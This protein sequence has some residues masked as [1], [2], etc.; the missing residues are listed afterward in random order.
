MTDDL[1]NVC[2]VLCT[3]AILWCAGVYVGAVVRAIV[4]S[5]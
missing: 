4:H 1:I 2:G 5:I 3:M